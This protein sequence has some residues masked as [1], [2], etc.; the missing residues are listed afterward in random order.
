MAVLE[1]L[2]SYVV[3]ELLPDFLRHSYFQIYSVFSATILVSDL[4]LRDYFK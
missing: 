3:H 2:L 1:V 4:V